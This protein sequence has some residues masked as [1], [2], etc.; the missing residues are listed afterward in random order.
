MKLYILLAAIVVGITAVMIIRE[1]PHPDPQQEITHEE[2]EK[3]QRR[4]RAQYLLTAVATKKGSDRFSALRESA[5]QYA[6]K[7]PDAGVAYLAS[8]P[9]GTESRIAITEFAMKL[10]AVERD[11]YAELIPSFQSNQERFTAYLNSGIGAVVAADPKL[12]MTILNSV[13]KDFTKA[14]KARFYEGLIE[15][16]AKS[17]PT[18]GWEILGYASEEPVTPEAR[19]R[20]LRGVMFRDVGS[21][22]RFFTAF[23][24]TPA[25]FPALV[26]AGRKI[27]D[28]DNKESLEIFIMNVRAV[29][30]VAV[31]D[32][33][34][35][36]AMDAAMLRHTKLAM[37]I[38]NRIEDPAA[39]QANLAKLRSHLTGRYPDLLLDVDY[40]HMLR[41]E[42]ERPVHPTDRKHD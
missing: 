36:G 20:F 26:A 32:K 7:D 25:D 22:N 17:D 28:T 11:K 30:N 12:A 5:A 35:E 37:L 8:L 31:R 14:E 10:A 1:N 18:Y 13:T 24:H 29:K 42:K 6:Q 2:L 40:L 19:E 33:L 23:D 4:I 21:I 34:L 16:L 15:I 3:K 38:L 41:M 39:Y 9:D 27:A